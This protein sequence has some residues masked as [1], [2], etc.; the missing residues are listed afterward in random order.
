MN[1]TPGEGQ[2]HHRRSS[3]NSV[4]LYNPSQP[5]NGRNHSQI[6]VKDLSTVNGVKQY[7]MKAPVAVQ[8]LGLNITELYHHYQN[9]KKQKY[10]KEQPS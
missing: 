6:G 8:D 3:N 7:N 2:K 10:F 5:Q 4:S 1:H 9:K